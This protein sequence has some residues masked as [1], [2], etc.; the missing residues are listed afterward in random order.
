M[1]IPRNGKCASCNALVPGGERFNAIKH[2]IGEH[3]YRFQFTC[4]N[5][6]T[7]LFMS[8]DPARA[9]FV[10]EHPLHEMKS[11]LADK[12][13]EEE[14]RNAAAPL[15]IE[16]VERKRAET[17]FVENRVLPR[18]GGDEAS[19]AASVRAALRNQ[20]RERRHALEQGRKR[21]MAVALLP[22]DASDDAFPAAS[23]AAASA[24]QPPFALLGSAPQRP[25]DVQLV[26]VKSKRRKAASA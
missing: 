12:R 17:A 1:A 2:T 8:T 23:A 9:E 10:F 4:K 13:R 6:K 24:K 5:C 25:S 26:V 20:R 18:A 21:G 14:A 19:R 3:A 16:L 22:A 15:P 11:Y 7:T